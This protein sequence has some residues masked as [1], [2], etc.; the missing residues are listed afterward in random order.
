M[1]KALIVDDEVWVR[2]GIRKKLEAEAYGFEWIG[3]ASDGEEAMEI[4]AAQRPHLVI[5]DIRMGEMDGI[6]LI[7]ETV[8]RYGGTQF[9]I[10]S[11]YGEFDYA[12][13]AINMGVAGYILKPVRDD[14][15]HKTISKIIKELER[16]NEMA[17]LSTRNEMLEKDRVSA[18]LQQEIFKRLDDAQPADG[19]DLTGRLPLFGKA[20][21]ALAILH[22]DSVS[23][24]LS[25]FKY[26]DAGLLKFAVKNIL[27]ELWAEE[28]VCILDDFKGGSRVLALFYSDQAEGLML[29]CNRLLTGAH[30]K[31][32]V[33]LNIKMTFAVSSVCDR[34]SSTL[35][36]RAWE[37]FES[38]LH[39]GRNCIYRYDQ[40]TPDEK[41]NIPEQKFTLLRRFFEQ[42]NFSNA[43]TILHDVFYNPGGGVSS[44]KYMRYLYTECVNIIFKAGTSLGV[45]V[46]EK[47]DSGALSGDLARQFENAGEIAEYLAALARKV[48]SPDGYAYIDTDGLVKKVKE[49]LESN[50]HE[51][52]SIGDLATIF[53]INPN[54]LSTVY[55][56]KTGKALMRHLMEIRVQ[57]ACAL[58]RDG[59]LSTVEISRSVGYHEPQY[60]YKVFKR[61]TGKTPLDFK[62]GT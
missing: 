1:Y 10:I 3:E 18:A 53:A 26:M 31:I 45:N 50:Y 28:D 44:G 41:F 46:A 19:D 62:N 27:N 13:Q 16:R 51:D 30:S 23:Y 54:Y 29:K 61:V 36:S 37:A 43:Q 42:R 22:I 52:I 58:L 20:A 21:F 6:E 2:K 33:L 24:S 7:R 12:E 38:G 35:Y 47:M 8:E 34:I 39:L 15:F 17:G 14:Q 57:H 32:T 48:L 49:Y 55:K 4:I 5:T 9:V 40:L 11:G 56:K 60:F 25:D 59:A